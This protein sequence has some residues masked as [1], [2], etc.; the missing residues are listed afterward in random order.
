MG[1]SERQFMVTTPC[2]FFAAA[3]GFLRTENER[4]QRAWERARLISY[5]S[6]APHI[7]SMKIYDVAK[8]DWEH[9][10][11]N[12]KPMT[13]DEIEAR[14]RNSLEMDMIMLKIH[15]NKIKN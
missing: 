6:S 7:K 4:E 8:F 14:E 2:F 11:P 13:Q 3:D 9:H 15:T 5:H 10:K 1:Y 12:K